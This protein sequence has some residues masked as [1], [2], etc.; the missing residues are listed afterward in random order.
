MCDM[1]LHA[2]LE[3]AFVRGDQLRDGALC[4]IPSPWL[5]RP[6]LQKVGRVPL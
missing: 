5:A 6:R 4:S 3:M 1:I 2:D